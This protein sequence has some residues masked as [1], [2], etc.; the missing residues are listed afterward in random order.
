MKKGWSTLCLFLYLICKSM[1]EQPVLP[2]IHS[3]W[4][5]IKGRDGSFFEAYRSQPQEPKGGILLFMEAFGVNAHIQSVARR[6]AAQG[7]LVLAP[8][9]YHRV[10]PRWEGKYD[11]FPLARQ[12]L[13][14][15]TISGLQ[16]DIY[17]CYEWLSTKGNFPS[18]RIGAVGFCLGGKVAFLAA[19]SLPIAAAVC[20]YGGGIGEL[21]N[22]AQQIRGGLLFFWGSQDP[23]IPLEERLKTATRLN[24]ENKSFIQVEFSRATHGFFCEERESYNKDAAQL[25]WMITLAFLQDQLGLKKQED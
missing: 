20:Y 5:K 13:K 12:F 9:L 8:D 2:A 17:G 7:Y 3:S 10:R 6:L 23:H 1:G 16:S 11:E 25:S 18:S 21:L 24:K 15:L 22:Q 19:E 14:T 4:E